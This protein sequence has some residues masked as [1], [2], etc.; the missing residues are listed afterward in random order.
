MPIAAAAL[1]EALSATLGQ[2]VLPLSATELAEA[3]AKPPPI[4]AATLSNALAATS[5]IE[6]VSEPEAVAALPGAQLAEGA[7]KLSQALIASVGPAKPPAAAG[8]SK[9][10]LPSTSIEEPPEHIF[11]PA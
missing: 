9:S 7:A 6:P 11:P 5:C 3:S 8:L 4:K 10:L 1:N 2:A